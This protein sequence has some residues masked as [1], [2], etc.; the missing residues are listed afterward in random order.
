[1]ARNYPRDWDWA[2]EERPRPLFDYLLAPDNIGFYELGY[3]VDGKFDPQYAGRAKGVTLRK[4]LGQHYR[5]SHN[6]SVRKNRHNLFFR[7]KVFET[8]ELVS[9]VEAVSIAAIEYPWNRRNE[10]AQHWILES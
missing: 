6:K 2:N 1:M 5:V 9:Y 10:W 4:R 3:M 7:C 8:E